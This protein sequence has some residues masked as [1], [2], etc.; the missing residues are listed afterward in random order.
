MSSPTYVPYRGYRIEVHVTPAMTRP[1][2]GA[3]RRYRVSWSLSSLQQPEQCVASFPEQF[4][5]LSEKDAFR[6]GEN[7]AH[8]YVDSIVCVPSRRRELDYGSEQTQPA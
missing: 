6:Y 8:T 7:R 3:G 5:F 4:D 1:I 2:G